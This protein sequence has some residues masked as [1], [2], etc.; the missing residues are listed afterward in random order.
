MSISSFFIAWYTQYL[1]NVYYSTISLFS[2]VILMGI[3]IILWHLEISQIV[4]IS[5]K[6]KI[7]IACSMIWLR[8]NLFHRLIIWIMQWWFIG[9][10]GTIQVSPQNVFCI[11]PNVIIKL[12]GFVC[13]SVS[14]SVGSIKRTILLNINIKIYFCT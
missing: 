13:L 10:M 1:Q 2:G 3:S 12:L 8:N 9:R 14:F 5:S 4:L 7:S 6:E 11:L